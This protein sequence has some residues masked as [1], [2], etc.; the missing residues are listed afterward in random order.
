MFGLVLTWLKVLL[1]FF[2]YRLVTA[3]ILFVQLALTFLKTCFC[4]IPLRVLLNFS[5]HTA[6]FEECLL[7]LCFFSLVNMLQFCL[8][9]LFHHQS[10]FNSVFILKLHKQLQ[11]SLLLFVHS[12][13]PLKLS[14]KSWSVYRLLLKGTCNICFTWVIIE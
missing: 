3:F 12:Y 5:A 6:L 1:L 8:Q 14:T 11:L 13:F 2:I 9:I 7:Y 10:Q 4:R